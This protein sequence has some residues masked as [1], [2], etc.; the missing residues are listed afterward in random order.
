VQAAI[1]RRHVPRTFHRE[2]IARNAQQRRFNPSRP[3][4]R[5]AHSFVHDAASLPL[6]MYASAERIEHVRVERDGRNEYQ[7][8][9]FA[10]LCPQLNPGLHRLLLVCVFGKNQPPI[11]T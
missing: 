9:V 6:S 3:R 2:R 4:Q 7:A 1:R 8:P 5:L 10:H 11:T